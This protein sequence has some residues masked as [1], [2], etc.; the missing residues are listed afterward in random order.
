MHLEDELLELFA[1]GVDAP[2][3]E[4][5]FN[6]LALAVFAHQFERNTPYGAYCRVRG[7]TG[8]NSGLSSVSGMCPVNLWYALS[9]AF[10][11]VAAVF[12]SASACSSRAS[13]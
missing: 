4:V 5:A 12:R 11:F 8:V 10:R 9:A 3:A 7:K 13:A 1:R 6:R 2:L